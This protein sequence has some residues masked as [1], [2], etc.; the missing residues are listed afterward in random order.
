MKQIFTKSFN[1]LF[2][3]AVFISG[4]LFLHAQSPTIVS[5]GSCNEVTANFNTND[6]GYN[7]PSVYAGAFDSSFYYSANRGY[8][9][10][11]A[12]PYRVT[13]PGSPRVLNIISPPYNNPNPSQVF[14]V[15]FY[16]IVPNPAVDRFQV[17]II[18]ITHTSVGDIANVEATSG[19]Q[20]F[21]AWS[22]PAAYTDTETPLLNGF[23]G[24]V[25]MR[26]VDANITNAPNVT[27][28]VEVSYIINEPLFAVFDN[29][30]LGDVSAAPLPVNFIGLVANRNNNN[31]LL[32]WDV[33]GEVDVAQYNIERSA[34][35][36][37][38]TTIGS[39]PSGGKHLYNFTDFNAGTGTLYYRVKS[40]DQNGSIK[41]S[42]VVRLQADAGNSYSEQLQMFPNP[43]NDNVSLQHKLLSEKARIS[44]ATIDGRILK[45]IVP[46]SRVSNTQI[47]VTDLVPGIYIIILNDGE[48]GLET[49][50]F[51]KQ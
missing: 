39:V 18:S 29:L 12:P 1:H 35:G 10:D 47:N 49:L 34:N 17:R 7:S 36:A 19:L 21:S 38:F 24:N 28:R 40:V 50:K 26:L 32:R 2:F 23:S 42:G 51:I 13:A 41:Y 15:G 5:P 3:T 37:S 33:I 20:Y 14:N 8:W 22:S 9:T 16:Y 11:Y 4:T 6:Q 44:V 27:Y 48:G 46:A 25:C 43:A 30:S 31:V 45:Q